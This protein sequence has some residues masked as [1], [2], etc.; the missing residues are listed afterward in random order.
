[1]SIARAEKRIG[2]VP[3]NDSLLVHTAWDLGFNDSTAIWY[4]QISGKEIWLIDYDEGSGES[5]SYWLNVLK[6]KDYSYGKHIAPHDIMVHEY[7]SGMTRQASARKMGINFIPAEKVQIIPGI[8]QVRSIL[9]RCWFD[10]RKCARGIKALDSYKKDWDDRHGCW[11]SQPL[12]D[13]S[14]HGSDAFRT[15]ATGLNIVTN[16]HTI[17]DAQQEAQRQRNY[18]ESR[19]VPQARTF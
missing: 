3:Y 6:K 18:L 9:N 12:H 5:L 14:S 11:R 16:Q 19:F 8:D 17:A 1:M 15:L 13:W 2:N 7:S 4:F 10:E